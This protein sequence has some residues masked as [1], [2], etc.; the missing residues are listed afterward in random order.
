M[1]TF[2]YT[3]MAYIH[4]YIYVYGV[5]IHLCIRIWCM[6]T[7]IYTYTALRQVIASTA[8]AMVKGP[9]SAEERRGL[10]LVRPPHPTFSTEWYSSQVKNNYSLESEVLMVPGCRGVDAGG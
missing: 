4:I 1:Y 9:M 10:E 8:A 3:Y 6:Y 5:Y 2:I 7:F